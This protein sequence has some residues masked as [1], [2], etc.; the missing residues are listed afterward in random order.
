MNLEGVRRILALQS[1]ND[2]LRA[3]VERLRRLLGEFEQ[4]MSGGAQPEDL[5]EPVVPH[6]AKPG[7][8]PDIRRPDP[9]DRTA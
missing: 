2:R 8:L 6:E 7:T 5:R 1:D 9:F 3:Q 4:R